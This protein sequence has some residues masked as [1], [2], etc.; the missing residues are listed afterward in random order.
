MSKRAKRANGDGAVIPRG[1]GVYRLR[2]T[3]NGKRFSQT[4][5][6][7][8][9]TEA[10]KKLR[11][12]L[13][14]A[15][16]GKH[17]APDKI[18][19]AQWVKQ[20]IEIGAPGRLKKAVSQRTLEGYEEKLRVHVVAVLGDRPLQ[21]LQATEFDKLYTKL[22]GKVSPRTAR[23]VHT[24]LN[25]CL[26]TAVRTKILPR[27]PLMDAQKIPAAG[28]SNHGIAL[29][30]DELRSLL[31]DFKKG[32]KGGGSILFPIVAVEAMTAARRG[33]VLA[34][35]WTDLD[36][37]NKTLAIQRALEQT[38]KHGIRFKEPKTAR[39]R[40]TLV[41]DDELLA[42]LLT[43]REK[44]LRFVA[45]V[46]DGATVDLSLVKLPDGAL[47][48]PNSPDPG[49]PFDLTKPRNPRNTTR[50]IKKVFRRLGFGDLRQH[51][52]RGTHETLL[53]DSG[54]PLHVVAT[55]GGHDPATLLKSY[56]KRTKKADK[57]AAA[58]IGA[59]AKVFL[60]NDGMRGPVGPAL[61]QVP[62][63]CQI[64]RSHSQ[65]GDCL[66]H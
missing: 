33:E 54:V 49:E 51:D 43:E 66:S 2:Y 42:M 25:S 20:W 11:A 37:A 50:R 1:N 15:T 10:T 7:T 23:H 19:L 57:N 61:A 55:R 24:I 62:T 59:L 5:R 26:N 8:T 13:H 34:L 30:G 28:E 39:G 60:A 48:F 63:G 52:L 29:D 22:E 31:T 9:K 12:I 16:E 4:L 45:G 27:N 53:L 6:D 56:A 17:V 35:R 44:H 40:R 32:F 18:T 36:I 64:V 41:I 58:V 38:K 3:L 21:Q 47:M 46:P 14:D 65:L